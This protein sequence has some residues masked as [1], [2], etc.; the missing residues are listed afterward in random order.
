MELKIRLRTLQ[1]TRITKQTEKKKTCKR[2][3][4]LVQWGESIMAVLLYR[5]AT[6][7]TI[8]FDSTARQIQLMNHSFKKHSVKL[9]IKLQIT[10]S[11]SVLQSRCSISIAL[12][13]RKFLF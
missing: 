5:N 11:S 2:P 1:I 7:Y 3:Y 10:L 8:S 12:A 9:E 13:I 4:M 6:N